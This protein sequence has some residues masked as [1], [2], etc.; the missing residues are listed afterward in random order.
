MAMQE[1]IQALLL[2]SVLRE[3][4]SFIAVVHNPACVS[5]LAIAA[6]GSHGV[7]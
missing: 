5:T 7:L 1:F 2:T 3:G 4:L 6:G